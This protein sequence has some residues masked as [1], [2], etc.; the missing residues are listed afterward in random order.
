MI[1]F[2]TSGQIKFLASRHASSLQRFLIIRYARLF[3]NEKLKCSIG[4]DFL[5]IVAVTDFC[6]QQNGGVLDWPHNGSVF[7]RWKK[8]NVLFFFS[9]VAFPMMVVCSIFTS[10]ST[11]G[12]TRLEPRPSWYEKKKVSVAFCYCAFK[13]ELIKKT[14][15]H[16]E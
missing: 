4:W 15:S 9:F 6:L 11:I 13:W 16:T 8:R 7:K 5:I 2:V 1:V 12:W 10:L 14:L 3:E